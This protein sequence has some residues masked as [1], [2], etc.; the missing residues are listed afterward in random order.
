MHTKP[1]GVLT[2]TRMSDS[3]THVEIE[4]EYAENLKKLEEKIRRKI[5]KER[6]DRL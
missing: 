6:V 3:K 2:F 1:S 5:L 4:E